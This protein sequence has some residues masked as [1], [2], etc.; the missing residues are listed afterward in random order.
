VVF[1]L[2]FDTSLGLCQFTGALWFL[3]DLASVID[4][5]LVFANWTGLPLLICV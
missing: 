3:L 5:C 1:S 2:P 4:L